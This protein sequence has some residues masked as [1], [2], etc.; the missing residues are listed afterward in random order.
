MTDQFC[1]STLRVWAQGDSSNRH[2]QLAMR[3][4]SQGSIAV[5]GSA[6]VPGTAIA[7]ALIALAANVVVLL[8]QPIP[9]VSAASGCLLLFVLPIFVL[10]AKLH[11]TWAEPAD[12]LG[13]SLA[14]TLLLLMT[15]GLAMNIVLPH[16]GVA[17]PLDRLPVLVCLDGLLLGLG[18][19]RPRRW[20]IPPR[21]SS[22]PVG[23]RSM[24]VLL[25][26]AFTVV[27]SIGGAIRLNNGAGGGLA[28][29]VL[30]VAATLLTVLVLWEES[31]SPG[32]VT[33]AVFCLALGVLLMSSL[34]GWYVTGID[35][36]GEFRVFQLTASS[37]SW[38][39]SRDPGAY[40]ACLSITVL[41]TVIQK[42]TRIPPAYVFKC[43]YPALF[44]IA[45]VLVYKLARKQSSTKLAL[46][47]VTLFISFPTFINEMAF[48]ARQ[49]I[50]FVFVVAAFLIMTSGE[51]P[52]FTRR[53]FIALCSVGVV[54]S[55]YSTAYILA[56][57][58]LTAWLLEVVSSGP[59]R[60][61][62]VTLSRVRPS[63]SSMGRPAS[64][65]IIG[66]V[67]ICILVAASL[68]WT[69]V[70][71]HTSS[72]LT[73][74]VRS[75]VSSIRG[76]VDGGSRSGDVAYGVFSLGSPT[77]EKIADDYA[78]NALR[79]TSSGRHKGLY[80]P[81][82]LLSDYRTPRIAPPIVLPT[83]PLGRVFERTGLR[84]EQLNSFM[85]QGAAKLYQVLLAAGLV[86]A[87]FYRPR[88]FTPP[89]EVLAIAL[90]ASLL[91]VLQVVLP[92]FSVNYGVQRAFQQALIIVCPFVALGAAMAF[93]WA[94]KGWSFNL[95]AALILL[96]F[97]SLSGA[98]PQMTGG[99]Q[100]QLNLN[101]AG[102]YYDI[103]YTHPQ[104]VAAA[105]WLARMDAAGSSPL[106]ASADRYTANRLQT[107]VGFAER[108]IWPYFLPRNGFV[109]LGYSNV[110]TSRSYF[111]YEG[112]M[113][114]YEYPMKALHSRKNLIYSSDGA[115]V[116]Q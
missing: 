39:M 42:I 101:D 104:E 43:V 61:I 81:L 54:L 48:I 30:L 100:P 89:R 73:A 5:R 31:L 110:M 90:A 105:R 20:P 51:G 79:E 68:V 59:L 10:S 96:L 33:T 84:V 70:Y 71:T 27:A 107:Y 102:Q 11:W 56:A 50:A 9:W 76:S 15:M 63:G 78:S 18:L 113:V 86:A 69:G 66:L 75:A 23:W 52:V 116:Y 13:Y 22:P 29:A 16:F 80:Y 26:C 103:A 72:G 88:R 64:G 82:S 108:D 109:L 97:L 14:A 3:D 17:R 44:A 65:R 111:S 36:Q 21:L 60:G 62:R 46:L 7:Y 6:R 99:Y 38:A 115:Q 12:R 1:P 40:N 49:E 53:V 106:R 67:N 35:M 45:T 34:R 57:T 28:L 19:W 25:M 2:R 32:L 41:P 94:R 87:F 83:T 92:V 91:V 74:T 4:P 77:Y 37:G 93:S 85:R 58:L 55:H 112:L 47:A 114:P 24:S 95:A 98:L 8:P